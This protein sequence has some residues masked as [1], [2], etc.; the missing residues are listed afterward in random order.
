MDFKL[1]AEASEFSFFAPP[2]EEE[3]QPAQEE[4]KQPASQFEGFK[5]N[6]GL[7]LNG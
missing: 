5:E 1:S 4:K 3:K 2:S 7:L 6:L